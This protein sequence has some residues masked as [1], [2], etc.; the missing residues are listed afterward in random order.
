MT[1]GYMYGITKNKDDVFQFDETDLY[2]SVDALSV[3]Y[4]SD[5]PAE[6]ATDMRIQ[7]LQRLTYCGAEV[8]YAEITDDGNKT[9][10][11]SYLVPYFILS[12]DVKREFFRDRFQRMKKW[13]RR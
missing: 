11:A 10:S 4:V 7:F 12:D 3:D 8:G 5:V 1:R 13:R 9:V 2:E 6:N